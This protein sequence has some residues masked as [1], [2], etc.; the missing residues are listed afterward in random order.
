VESL[1]DKSVVHDTH[2]NLIRSV[3][4]MACPCHSSSNDGSG[5]HGSGSGGVVVVVVVVVK[6]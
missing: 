6:Q 3:S 1:S 4:Y 2:F 5:S